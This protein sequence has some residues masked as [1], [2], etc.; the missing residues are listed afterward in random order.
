L[1]K[2]VEKTKIACYCRVSTEKEEQLASLNKQ[3]EFFEDLAKQH[4]YELVKTYADEGISGKQ[5]KNRLQFQQMI[6][7]ASLGKFSLILVK[8]ISRFSRNT[9]DFLHNIRKLKR[10]GCDVSFITQGMKVQ[11]TSEAYLTI[12]AAMAQDE[13]SKLS[14][15]VKFGKD[16]TAKKGRVPNFVFG[17]NRLDS[18][19]L[20]V[21]EKEGAIVEKI[22]DLFVNKG[23]GSGKIAGYLNDLKV[24]TKRTKKSKWHQVVVCQILR[25]RLYTGRVVNKQSQVIDF[26]TGTREAIPLEDQIVVDKPEF[27]IIDDAT[28]NKA[29]DIL[30][31]RRDTFHMMNK[32][33]STKYPLSNL[34]KCSECGYSF[35][36]M[37]RKYSDNGKTYKR[38]VDSL[39]N[40]MG[41][42]AC[43]NKVIVDE[44]EIEEAIKLFLQQIVRNKTKLI[45]ETSSILKEIINEKNKHVINNQ[46]DTKDELEKIIK[47][48]EKYMDMYKNEIIE[49]DELKTYTKTLNDKISKLKISI[50][51]ANNVDEIALNIED[52][53][54]KYFENISDIIDEGTYTNVVLKKI[55]N[56]IVIY[57]DGEVKIS[58]AINNKHDLNMIIP[59]DCIELPI[60]IPVD[61][62]V[63][64]TNVYTCSNYNKERFSF[65]FQIQGYSTKG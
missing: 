42:N 63:P 13:S 19:T 58:L 36:R 46:E 45:K 56:S 6:K 59:L 23:Y 65:V 39:R 50:H 38:W 52:I 54:K 1:E 2:R 20:V 18:Y 14:D 26:I 17:Y 37:Q 53:V 8:D 15:K 41:K 28:F 40:T 43:I 11:E 22:F 9:E 16:I 62:T 57:P 35:R 10:Y 32:K 30:E 33:E 61:K 31:G 27:R 49:M 47:Q 44:E 4:N 55:I 29:Q 60:E 64:N 5:L 34:I 48:K 24:V 3:I 7:D 25:N 51:A 21:D 12:M